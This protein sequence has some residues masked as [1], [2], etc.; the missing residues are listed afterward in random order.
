MIYRYKIGDGEWTVLED[1][2][3][4]VDGME[5]DLLIKKY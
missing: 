2:K 3:A 4:I 5:V 1:S